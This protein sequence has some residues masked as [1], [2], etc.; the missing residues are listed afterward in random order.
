MSCY[1]TFFLTPSPL[2]PPPPPPP[3]SFVGP[4][5][6]PHRRFTHAQ[7]AAEDQHPRHDAQRLRGDSRRVD[8]PLGSAAELDVE[9]VESGY[10]AFRL[11]DSS[12]RNSIRK[13]IGTE[14][15][16][17]EIQTRSQRKCEENIDG[18]QQSSSISSSRAA[19]RRG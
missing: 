15:E 4:R 8:G 18:K 17:H 12:Q 14:D 6:F 10:P 1:L 2:P 5:S 16:K 11:P 3:K 19:E 13:K 7:D 9:A